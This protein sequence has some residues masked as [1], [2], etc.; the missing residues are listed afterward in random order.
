MKNRDY[1]IS[2]KRREQY[3]Q[4]SKESAAAKQ[5]ALTSNEMPYRSVN[6]PRLDPKSLMPKLPKNSLRTLSLFSGGGGLDLGFDRAGYDHVASYDFIPV[7]GD[8]LKHNRP[9]WTVHSGAD[10]GDVRNLSVD[11]YTDLVDV[12]HGGP[13]CQPF[14]TSGQ[15]AG[16]D[17]SRNMWGPFVDIINH[18]KPRAFIGENVPGLLNTKFSSYVQQYILSP[19]SDYHIHAF[20]LN[21]AGFGVPQ[22][23]QRVFFVGF[24]SKA[25][26]DAFKIP[27]YTH[28][29]EHL[30]TRNRKNYNEQQPSL[31]GEKRQCFGIR[32]ALGFPDIGK[33]AL[34]PTIRSAFTGKRNTTSI[35]NSSAAARSL[36]EIEVWGS[37]VAANR[38]LASS[39]RPKN[40]HYRLSV[41]D[42]A[43]LQGFPESWEF[44]GA[45]Y[46]ILGQIGNSVAPPVAYHV[47][48]SVA[49]ALER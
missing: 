36:A 37:G 33:D 32:E 41:Q 29:F 42:C 12:I 18:V 45:V 35:L 7:C 21:S 30:L 11:E 49:A 25:D 16:I 48:K 14:S 23:R 26:A 38:A 6:H 40:G 2:E 1:D 28:D 17:D 24:R 13:P 46:K 47:A 5:N 19:L 44:Q 31:W 43:L 9:D 10:V 4:S 8:T 20:K 27:E 34:C 22:K 39:F 3:R 15:G